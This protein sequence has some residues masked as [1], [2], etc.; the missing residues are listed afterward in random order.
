MRLFAVTRTRGASWNPAV[1]LEQQEDW[2][3]HAAS[4]NGLHAEGFVLLGGPLKDT[5]EVLLVIRAKDA[6]E[7]EGRLAEDSWTKKGL[8]GIKQIAPWE[9]R[10]GA[11]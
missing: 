3:G 2:T 11:L 8:L 7:I 5:A 4:M 6:S 9:L 1:A 10:L